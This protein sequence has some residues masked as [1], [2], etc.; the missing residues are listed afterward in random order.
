MKT[1]T[2][3]DTLTCICADCGKQFALTADTE[4]EGESTYLHI[5][6]CESGGIYGTYVDC[7]H[8]SHHH[9]LYA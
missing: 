5:N 6:S 1:R 4:K 9:N 2:S 8:C 7:P 3:S